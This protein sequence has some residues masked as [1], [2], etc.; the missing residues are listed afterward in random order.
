MR[1]D[2]SSKTHKDGILFLMS[3]KKS[4]VNMIYNIK[5][6]GAVADGT[7]IDKDL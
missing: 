1:T 3:K 4:E 6:F 5:N 7:T 2:V